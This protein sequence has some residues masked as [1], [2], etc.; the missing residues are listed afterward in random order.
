MRW[1]RRY[2]LDYV[3]GLGKPWRILTMPIAPVKSAGATVCGTALTTERRTKGVT[4]VTPGVRKAREA[5]G[6]DQDA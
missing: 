1:G 2:I 6:D 4:V 3:H 5:E